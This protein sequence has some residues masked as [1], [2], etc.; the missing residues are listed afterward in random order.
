[1]NCQGLQLYSDV[2]IAMGQIPRLELGIDAA[3]V[4]RN[5]GSKTGRLKIGDRVAFPRPG[6]M[7]SVVRVRGDLPQLLP[8]NMSF[9]DGASIPL[10]F[11]AAYRSLIEVAQLSKGESVLIRSAA[12]G[13]SIVET[14]SLLTGCFFC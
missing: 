4:V 14:T 10:V 9:E 13:E 2:S 12:G 6:K 3:G 11:M 7:S 1:M 5:V 8:E